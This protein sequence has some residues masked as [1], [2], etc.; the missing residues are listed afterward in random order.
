MKTDLMSFAS[1]ISKSAACGKSIPTSRATRSCAC[2]RGVRFCVVV[3][4]TLCACVA[5]GLS[6]RASAASEAKPSYYQYQP[7]QP[8]RNFWRFLENCKIEQGRRAERRARAIQA[9]RALDAL[10]QQQGK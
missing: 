8:L 9:V 7:F 3:I 1:D 4:A 2:L 6:A 5:T 10:Q